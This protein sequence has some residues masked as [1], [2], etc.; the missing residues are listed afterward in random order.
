[1]EQDDRGP[2][3]GAGLHVPDVQIA[4]VDLAEPPE[5]GTGSHICRAH[6]VSAATA[7]SD[8]RTITSVTTCG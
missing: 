7:A 4:R 1:M 2:D 3:G 6:R 8:A 5:R